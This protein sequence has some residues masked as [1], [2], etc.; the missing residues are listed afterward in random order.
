VLRF[1]RYPVA[2]KGKRFAAEKLFKLLEQPNNLLLGSFGLGK[3]CANPRNVAAY[4]C[5][6]AQGISNKKR[7][8]GTLAE[9]SRQV[10]CGVYELRCESV[11]A[12]ATTEGL[13]E[14]S[15]ADVVHH[16]EHGE[17]AHAA[18]RITLSPERFVNIEDTKTGHY[19]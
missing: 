16:P 14:V 10:H 19:R 4:G 18:L 3:I 15:S 13:E 8:E 6:L 9:K 7:A 12:L 1:S 5:R 2:S 11:R 17:L